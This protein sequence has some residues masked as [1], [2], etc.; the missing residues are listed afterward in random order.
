[1]PLTRPELRV[2]LHGTTDVTGRP[3]AST[4]SRLC[5]KAAIATASIRAVTPSSAPSMACAT[6]FS[7]A[8]GAA[9]TLPSL[10]TRQR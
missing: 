8:A 3:C 9:S 7:I 2:S 6:A 4:P 10:P 5:Q 1:M